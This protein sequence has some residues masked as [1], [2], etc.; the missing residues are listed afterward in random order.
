MYD[1]NKK[2]PKKRK[3][4]NDES[5]SPISFKS[6]HKSKK[7][8]EALLEL[9]SCLFHLPAPMPSD[10]TILISKPLPPKNPPQEKKV[11]SSELIASCADYVESDNMTDES[12]RSLNEP[13]LSDLEWFELDMRKGYQ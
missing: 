7:S 12:K 6:S 4:H 13:D 1:L 5:E 2:C 8:R 10:S 3:E 11:Q 9:N